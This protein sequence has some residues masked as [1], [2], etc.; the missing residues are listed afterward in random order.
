M[1]K[2]TGVHAP[3]RF[4]SYQEIHETVMNQFLK[5]EFVG[6]HSLRF[7]PWQRFNDDSLDIIPQIRLKGEIACSGRILVTVNKYLDILEESGDN[8]LVQTVS[9]A[10]NASVQGFGSIFRYD[11][12]DDYF[13]A[14]S[15]H[16][17]EHHKH[18]FNWRIKDE[19]G[20]VIWIGYE[21]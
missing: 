19:I 20:E 13:V 2:N 16:L 17:D 4:A 12:Q 3:N 5:N 18:Q 11:N 6:K 14:N 1:K 8:A 15:G 7:D 21:N 10:Y 9:Y